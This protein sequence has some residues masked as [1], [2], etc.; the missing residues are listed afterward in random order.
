MAAVRITCGLALA[1]SDEKT[2][3][4]GGIHSGLAKLSGSSGRGSEAFDRIA[5]L[6]RALSDGFKGRGLPKATSGRR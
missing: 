6:F 3:K 1:T 4:G 2:L 5:V